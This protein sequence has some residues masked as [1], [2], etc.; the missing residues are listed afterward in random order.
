MV[1]QAAGVE[2][3]ATPET[4]PRVDAAL[5]DAARRALERHGLARTTLERI[6]AE[7][8]LSRVTLYRRGLTREAILA[9]LSDGL[10]ESYREALW[11]A[12]TARGTGAER[13][14]RAL[15]AL[16]DVA[17]RRLELLLAL[18]ERVN[19]ALELG[20]DGAGLGGRDFTEPLE[21]ILRDGAADRSLREVDARE[22]ALA[23]FNL[24][25]WTYVHLRAGSRWS[26]R[27]ARRVTL[28]L[29]L[30]G[31]AAPAAAPSR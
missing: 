7:A 26:A 4:T 25:L 12:L 23:L 17:E 9:A 16:C 13:L 10:L 14:R 30:R 24:A 21:R 28:E 11:P 15:A 5:L 8:G 1:A 27:R 19:A 2:A 18:G 20:G 6:A 3:P 29:A 22:T 31:V